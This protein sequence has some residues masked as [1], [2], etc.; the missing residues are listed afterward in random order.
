L[1]PAARWK[2]SSIARAVISGLPGSLRRGFFDSIIGVSGILVIARSD[3]TKQSIVTVA[4]AV[5]CFAEPVIGR[6]FARPVG[7]Q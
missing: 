3:A 1:K 5:D 6:A 7:S 2:T 4:L